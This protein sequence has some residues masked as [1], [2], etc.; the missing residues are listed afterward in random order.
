MDINR[1][2]LPSTPIVIQV[3]FSRKSK[4]E[5]QNVIVRDHSERVYEN[6]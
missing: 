6:F 1:D 3:L 4:A 5:L 2:S